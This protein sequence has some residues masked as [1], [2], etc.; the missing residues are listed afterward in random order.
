MR[1][2]PFVK[3]KGLGTGLPFVSR[4]VFLVK[5]RKGRERNR[6]S[7]NIS[8]HKLIVKDFDILSK[9]G[10]EFTWAHTIEHKLLVDEGN[11]FWMYGSMCILDGK[12]FI[13]KVTKRCLKSFMERFYN[14]SRIHC[15]KLM[16]S[17][18]KQEKMER[19]GLYHLGVVSK[20]I[21]NR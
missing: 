4:K 16:I 14:V 6:A 9:T 15:G 12:E 20:K 21:I 5:A 3:K 8:L 2:S 11:G 7:W 19:E 17:P 13:C 1:F 18:V 10:L